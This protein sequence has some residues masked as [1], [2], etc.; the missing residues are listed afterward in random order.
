VV[1]Q[2]R[3]FSRSTFGVHPSPLQ[4]LLFPTSRATGLRRIP[5]SCKNHRQD[6][7]PGPMVS[8]FRGKSDVR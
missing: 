1:A 2:A 3:A 4:V 8:P 7:H 6:P 5:A